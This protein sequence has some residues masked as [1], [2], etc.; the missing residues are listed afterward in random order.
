MSGQPVTGSATKPA[1]MME[2]AAAKWAEWKPIAIGVVIGLIAGPIVS[3]IAGFQTRTSTAE[4]ATRAG[5][6][7]QQAMFCAERARGAMPAGAA[8]PEW[9][10]RNEL[11]R[12]WAIMPGATTA[13][14]EVVYACSGK[15]AG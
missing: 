8:V 11:A 5:I 6:V 10:A 7:E 15:L 2:T 13:D 1:T 3:S 9:N 14:P 4:A 12:K